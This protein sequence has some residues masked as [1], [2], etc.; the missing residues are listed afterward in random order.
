MPA[1]KS[2]MT[3]PTALTET[4][5]PDFIQAINDD[6][7]SQ[8]AHVF[9]LHGNIY[10]F[11]DNSGKDLTVKQVFSRFYDDNFLKDT[12]PD[13]G[14]SGNNLG[15]NDQAAP[16]SM[17][18]ILVT[19]NLSQGLEFPHPQSKELMKAAFTA[20]LGGELVNEQFMKPKSIGKLVEFMN[21]W[22][23]ISK[24]RKKTNQIAKKSGK[25]SQELLLVTWLLTDA[26]AMFPDG[27][28]SALGPDR[29]PIVSVRQWAQDEWL[30]STNRIILMCRHASDLHDSIRSEISAIHMVRKPNLED[31]VQYIKGFDSTIQARA[32]A[33][34]GSLKIGK[35][36]SVSKINWGDDFGPLQCAVQSAGMNRKQ[37]K[38]VFLQSWMG[39]E[40]VGYDQVRARKQR[41][42]Q[43]EYQG[44]IDFKEPE[45]GFEEIGG[46][47]AFKK[48]CKQ[49]VIM[50]LQ[51]GDK[52]TCARGALLC[53]PPGTGKSMLAWALAKEAKMNYLIVDL[54]KVF[55]GLVGETESNMRKLL[56]A[57]EAAAPCIVFIDEID[58]VLSAGRTSAGDSG[59]SGRVFNSFMTFMSDPG[60]AGKIVVLAATNR[61][62]LLDPALI[63]MGRFDAKIAILPPSRG[64]I[65]GRKAILNALTIKHKVKLHNELKPTLEDTESGLGRLLED[66]VRIWTGAEIEMVVKKAMSTAAFAERKDEEGNRDY[67]IQ[68]EDWNHAMDVI[69]PNT[70]EV[71]FQTKLALYFVDDLDFC[72]PDWRA[73]VID[74][75]SLGRELGLIRERPGQQEEE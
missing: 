72:P 31:R 46:H 68:L 58:S 55:G 20:E 61:P 52:R 7:K 69:L 1:A 62:D 18:R 9:L 23:D 25:A 27:D 36:T 3:A 44:M 2:A 60:R 71:E 34:G 26:D 30:A 48:F 21:L 64:D 4:I 63:R 40:P 56:E 24:K 75:E 65:K 6:Y 70:N 73:M 17:T 53:G 29:L 47:E 67:T 66:K 43:D 12:D 45:F 54:S 14:D 35:N 5:M 42:L 49:Q 13:G 32:K 33:R 50:P 74:K 38:D 19:Y 28:I 11:C 8:V 16:T 22:F 10:D 39:M 51:T 37:L 15:E 41:A 57:I 59:T